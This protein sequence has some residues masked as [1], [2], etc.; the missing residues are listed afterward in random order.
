[1]KHLTKASLWLLLT[2]VMIFTVGCG[3]MKK[4]NEI[5]IYTAGGKGGLID[6]TGKIVIEPQFDDI[7]YFSE[8]LVWVVV[9]GKYGFIDKSGQMVVKAQFDELLPFKEGLAVVRI[10]GKYGFIDKIGQVVIE[11]QFD[12]AWYFSEG[13][14]SVRI[15]DKCGFIDKTGRMVVEPR[16]D[17][18]YQN[19][20]VESLASVK[21]KD[22]IGD[23]K[24]VLNKND[25]DENESVLTI[26]DNIFVMIS[27]RNAKEIR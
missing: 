2:G 16:F 10:D 26:I 15:G 25:E 19:S 24:L 22:K 12:D 17:N 7:G 18:F 21:I 5:S 14:S 20:F 4:A 8:G 3:T 11:P 23:L 13:M 27:E 6:K 1:M 9:D